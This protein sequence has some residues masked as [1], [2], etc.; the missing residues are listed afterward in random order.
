MKEKD[1]Y[2]I[3]TKY[4]IFRKYQGKSTLIIDKQ[5][6]DLIKCINKDTINLSMI[7]L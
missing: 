4:N 5:I 7:L 1:G 3:G 2:Y 6:E